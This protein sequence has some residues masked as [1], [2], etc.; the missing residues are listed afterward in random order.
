MS[1]VWV[2]G[3]AAVVLLVL[4]LWTGHRTLTSPRARTGGVRD[5]M[6]NFIDVF[7][8]ARSRA[9]LDLESRK[10]QGA[11]LPSPDDDDRPMWTVDLHR[12][13]IT[14]PRHR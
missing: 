11:L 1:T 12:N 6:G 2:V 13:R 14:I 5:A 9:D 4:A 10:N 8:P 3:P 7:D